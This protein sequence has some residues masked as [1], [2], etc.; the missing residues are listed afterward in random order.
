VRFVYGDLIAVFADDAS[1]DF[2]HRVAAFAASGFKVCAT[3]GDHGSGF[4]SGQQL[5]LT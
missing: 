1:T 4:S 2:V 5:T 3:A